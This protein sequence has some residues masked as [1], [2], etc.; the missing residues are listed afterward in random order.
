MTD[1]ELLA[2]N[3]KGFLPGPGESEEDFRQRV[4]EV[5]KSFFASGEQSIPYSHWDW[6]RIHL[7]EV[8]DFMPDCLPAFYSDKGLMP[9][10]G[11]ASWIDGGRIASIQLRESLRKG[12]YLGLY[13]REEIL[14]HE[15]VHAARSAF[16]EDRFEEFFAYA[17]SESRFR[18]VLGPIVRRPWEVWPFLACCFAGAF[19]PAAFLGA[20]LWAALGFARLARGHW[21]LQ[22]A[23]EKLAEV[24]DDA[25]IA[26]AV[27]LRL[28]DSEIEKVGRGETVGDASLR[29]R[30]IR[31]AYWKKEG[32]GTENHR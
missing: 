19:F 21:I 15:V 22:K 7:R 26:R 10:Q 11:A 17:T 27:L 24:T 29:W 6:A 31:L 23:G 20:G 13:K 25:R 12:H 16:K 2:L 9:W 5:K 14:V 8:Y 4:E 30:L 28:S 18:R 1:E 3:Q 32:Y